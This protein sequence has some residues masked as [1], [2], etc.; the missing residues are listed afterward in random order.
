MSHRAELLAIRIE[1]GAAGLAA[2]V[3]ELSE[4]EWRMPVSES[5]RRSIGVIVHHAPAS[6]RL[7]LIW[8]EVSRAVRR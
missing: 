6:I 5:D 1:E 4:A 3:Q 8:R 2:Y 7:K